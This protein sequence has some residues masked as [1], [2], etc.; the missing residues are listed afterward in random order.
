MLSLVQLWKHISDDNFEKYT[1]KIAFVYRSVSFYPV[2]SEWMN[3][4]MNTSIHPSMECFKWENNLQ[5]LGIFM[6]IKCLIL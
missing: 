6:S 4:G 3:E 2:T 1:Q 5:I